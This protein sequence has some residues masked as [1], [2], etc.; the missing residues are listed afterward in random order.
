MSVPHERRVVD[1]DFTEFF[2]QTPLER[3]RWAYRQLANV[4]GPH[5]DLGCN[6]GGFTWAFATGTN[7][8]T[9]GVDVPGVELPLSHRAVDLVTADLD[10]GLPFAASSF[11]S[12]SL[13]DVLEHVADD[14]ALLVEAHRVLRPGGLLVVTVP[15]QHRWS[16]LDPDDAL[17]RF[18][19]LHHAAWSLRFGRLG[20]AKRFTVNERGVTGDIAAVRGGHTNYRIADLSGRV[21]SAGFRVDLMYT[22]GRWFRW[23]QLGALML[24]GGLGRL[25]DAGLRRDG[26]RSTYELGP[27]DKRPL[28]GN[29][30]VVATALD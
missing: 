14:V 27:N 30:F 12:V 16:I 2:R 7:R 10:R 19:R 11:A 17:F 13:L 1:G 21:R 20:Y 4:S 23:W 29:L 26:R 6:I 8:W 25:F 9:V 18:P 15:A 22:S 3:Y 5:L 28:G 24:P